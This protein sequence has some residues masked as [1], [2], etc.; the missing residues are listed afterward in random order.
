M[1]ADSARV[2]IRTAIRNASHADQPITLRTVVYDA[3][4]KEVAAAASEAR[5]PRDSV[6]ETAQDLIVRSPTLWSVERPYLYR[7]VSRVTCR[8]ILCD[9]YAT[10]FGVRTFSFDAGQGFIL[11]G[12]RLKIRGVC[13]HHDLGSLG[14]AVNTRALE[15]QLQIMKAMGVNA[16]RTSHNPPAPE[17]LDLADRMGFIVMDE[18]FDMWKKE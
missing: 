17:L 8:G 15:R 5:V 1:T 10:P 7:A 12:T 16:I 9:D 18:A 13:M 11:N 2:T 14:A 3:A 4:G 6:T